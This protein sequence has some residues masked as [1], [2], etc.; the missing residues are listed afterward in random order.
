MR[1]LSIWNTTTRFRFDYRGQAMLNFFRGKSLCVVLCFAVLISDRPSPVCAQPA[2]DAA[3]KAPA[4]DAPAVDAPAGRTKV[5]GSY[6]TWFIR[7]SGLIGLLILGLSIYFVATVIRLFLEIREEVSVPSHLLHQSEDLLQRNDL[8]TVYSTIQADDSILG[9]VLSA[10]LSEL[11][12]GISEARE[13]MDRMSES[14]TVRL[15][16]QIS[17][18]AVLGT[19]GPMIGL[20]GTLKG[21][22]SSFSV[23]AMSDVQLKASEVASGI[24]EA[25]LLTFEGVALSVPAIYFHA[26]F[27][28][29]VSSISAATMVHA[30][31]LLRH[32]ARAARMTSPTNGAASA[33]GQLPPWHRQR[34]IALRPLSEKPR[35]R[36]S[37]SM[38]L[39]PP[40]QPNLTPILDMVFQLITFFMLVI[41]FRMRRWI[42]VSSYPWSG[43]L[44]PHQPRRRRRAGAEHQR[45]RSADGLRRGTRHRPVCGSGGCH[46]STDCSSHHARLSRGRSLANYGHLAGGPGNSVS[47]SESHHDDMSDER[48]SAVFAEGFESRR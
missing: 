24:S 41:N 3:V 16:K 46:Q 36:W 27:R 37:D 34:L 23:I 26:L 40:T 10:G 12:Y 14:E 35:P 18:L 47:D 1:N 38:S 17:M 4:A 33:R 30:D 15:E 32:I 6:L 13:A 44:C 25:L 8:Q 31:R 29:R 22:I 2:D 28:N 5:P 7:S 39:A 19:L 42:V 9:H 48:F 45:R 43:R 21:M 20:I 11:P